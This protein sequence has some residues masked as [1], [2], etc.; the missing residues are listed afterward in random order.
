MNCPI[1]NEKICKCGIKGA[2][3]VLFTDHAMYTKFVIVSVFDETPNLNFLLERLLKNQEDIG[4]V[5]KPFTSTEIGNKIT[6][7]LKEHIKLAGDCLVNLKSKNMTELNKSKN[8]LFRNS[9]DFSLYLSKINSEKYPYEEIKEQ[10][11]AHNQ[12][13]IDMALNYHS[14]NFKNEIELYDQYFKHMMMFSD[15]I[16]SGLNSSDKQVGGNALFPINYQHKY[17]KYKAKYLNNNN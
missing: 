3:R 13:V 7:I 6:E 14:K 16:A 15:L 11:D 8:E 17:M 9:N 10:F 2:L 12:H 1:T 4:N 5:L